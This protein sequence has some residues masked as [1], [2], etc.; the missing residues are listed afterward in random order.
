MLFL[1]SR[2]LAAH[3]VVHGFSV[4]TGGVSAPPWDSLNL[5]GTV[6][7][8][9]ADVARNKALLYEAVGVSEPVVSVSQVHGDRVLEVRG[10]ARPVRLF[11][12]GA[13]LEGAQ[14]ADGLVGLE[15]AVVAVRTADCVP[16]LLFDPETGAAAAVHAGWRGTVAEVVRRAVERMV[17]EAGTDPQ[18]LLAAIGPSIGPCCFEVGAEVAQRFGEHPLL[19]ETVRIGEGRVTVDLHR[20]NARL[21]EAAGM[22][23]GRVEIL[24]DCTMCDPQ[25]FFSHR[26]DAGRTGRHLSLIRSGR[27]GAI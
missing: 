22:S 17:A 15:G 9:P 10:G 8:D 18:A 1:R 25:R 6:G 27:V 2:L 14:E 20:A 7:D 5:G 24:G 26:R 23:P 12:R 3:G 16:V 13:P 4:R 11:E 19:A 21:L